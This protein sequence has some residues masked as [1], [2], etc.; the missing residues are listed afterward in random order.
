MNDGADLDEVIA[1]AH[2]DFVFNSEDITSIMRKI[3]RWYDVD[4]SYPQG[5]P[6]PMQFDGIVSRSKNI[7][8]VLQMM[9]ATGKVKFK[10]E[11]RRIMVIP[12]P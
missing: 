10:I 11:K 9:E 8:A 3:A 1:W 5:S 2:G 7:S 4:I 6:G 12:K